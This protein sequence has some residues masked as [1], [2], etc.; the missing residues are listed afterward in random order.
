MNKELVKVYFFQTLF[1]LINIIGIPLSIYYTSILLYSWAFGIM[2]TIEIIYTAF[3]I[4]L[5][6]FSPIYKYNLSRMIYFSIGDNIKKCFI[7]LDTGGRSHV[8]RYYKF[9]WIGF[10]EIRKSDSYITDNITQEELS[11]IIKHDLK[12]YEESV[13]KAREGKRISDKL[14]S[15]DGI[16][17]DRIDL[18]RNDNIDKLL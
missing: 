10:I 2:L 14:K 8:L 12:K 4:L 18:F 15:W 1:I 17:T 7:R 9:I 13:Y 5:S 3:F 6:C 11:K 16:G